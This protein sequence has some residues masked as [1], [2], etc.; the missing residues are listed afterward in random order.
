MPG[1]IGALAVRKRRAKPPVL[2]RAR[3][4]ALQTVIAARCI[5][6]IAASRLTPMTPSRHLTNGTTE[7]T[8]N[9]ETIVGG[10]LDRPGG[11]S[12]PPRGNA[13]RT[14]R[15][16]LPV[17]PPRS[18]R[19][20]LGVVPGAQPRRATALPSLPSYFLCKSSSTAAG[21]GPHPAARKR[22]AASPRRVPGLLRCRRPRASSAASASRIAVS[23]R[24]GSGWSFRSG[25][26]T[27]CPAAEPGPVPRRPRCC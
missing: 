10:Q 9:D 8:S 27:E 23:R 18:R 7:G 20:N 19:L 11:C 3:L 13:V 1:R 17:P 12:S 21:M 15:Q 14:D 6:Y 25:G 16:P 5:D 4:F 22:P 26:S 2:L 24:A